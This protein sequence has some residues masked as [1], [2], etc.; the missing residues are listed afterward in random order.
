MSRTLRGHGRPWGIITNI[1]GPAVLPA[2]FGPYRR[3]RIMVADDINKNVYTQ[4]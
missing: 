1:E 4:Q 3:A 2:R